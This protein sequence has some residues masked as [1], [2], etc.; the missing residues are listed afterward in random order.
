MNWQA[1]QR[2]KPLKF[3]FWQK[4]SDWPEGGSD[5]SPKF[6]N[7]RSGWSIL[8]NPRFQLKLGGYF[9]FIGFS[10]LI[11]INVTA[12]FYFIALIDIG[13]SAEPGSD[14]AY[15][16]AETIIKHSWEVALGVGV[17]LMAM[18][19]FAVRLSHSIAGPAFALSRHID[20][21]INGDY[22]FKSRLREGDELKELMVKLNTLSDQLNH[23]ATNGSASQSTAKAQSD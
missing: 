7:R 18:I 11:L 1:W 17:F 12:I 2:L 22:S 20:A 5:T 4:T 3:P 23:Q 9:Q 13:S 8:V 10:S 6:K 15:M 14:I 21:L 19:V 16:L